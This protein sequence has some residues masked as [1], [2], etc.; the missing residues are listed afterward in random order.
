[1][2]KQTPRSPR[3]PAADD[4]IDEVWGDLFRAFTGNPPSEPPAEAPPEPTAETKPP[5]KP[6][7]PGRR[8]RTR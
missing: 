1:M 5:G 4:G 2:T 3:P 8:R 6:K 7:P